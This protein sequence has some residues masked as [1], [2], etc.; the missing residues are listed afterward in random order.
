MAIFF[1][2]PASPDDVTAFTREVPMEANRALLGLFGRRD[3][4]D[5][6]VDWAEIVRTNRLARYRSFDGRIHVSERDS[7][8]G[9]RLSLLPLSSSLNMGE[10]ERLQLQWARLGGT[11]E[12]ALADAIYNDAETLT[13]EVLNR[14]EMAWGDVL[15][16]GILQISEGGI[17]GTAGRIDFGVPGNQKVTVGTAWATSASATPLADLQAIID[18]YIDANGAPPGA[19]LTS[20]KQHRNLRKSAEIINAVYGTS[21]GKNRVSANELDDILSGELNGIELLAPYDATFDLDGSTVRVLPDDK[22]ILLPQG[23]A[24]A[25]GYT[26]WGISATALELAGSS[27]SDLTFENA[28]GIV[29][30]VEKVGPPY[31]QFTFVDAIAM[32]VLEDGKKI[33]ILD[34]AP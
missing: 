6:T 3:V 23:G 18:V 34:V 10:Y 13:N 29:G 31:R 24:D 4:L 17:G 30:V 27:Q 1:D 8:S 21:S 5:N 11:R 32:P 9:K 33:A 28:P 15:S 12:Q 7:A 22:A 2:A 16:D 25:L 14:L 26:A 20:N 19:I